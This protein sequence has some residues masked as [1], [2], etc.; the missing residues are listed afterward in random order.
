MMDIDQNETITVIP[1]PPDA[2]TQEIKEFTDRL[3]REITE[4]CGIKKKP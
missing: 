4:R 2:K 3:L 1:I